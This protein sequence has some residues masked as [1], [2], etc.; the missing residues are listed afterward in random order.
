MDDN[1]KEYLTSGK[2]PIVADS[3]EV[4]YNA[5]DDLISKGLF[6]CEELS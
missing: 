5:N 3:F 4:R 6:N 1:S 2:A